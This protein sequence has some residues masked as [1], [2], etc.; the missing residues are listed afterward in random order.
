MEH[1]A[2]LDGGQSR[3][4]SP[5]NVDGVKGGGGRASEG[6][7]AA[8]AA[9]LGVGW[10]ISPSVDIAAGSTFELAAIDGPA[11]IRARCSMPPRLTPPLR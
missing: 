8:C 5:E 1:L 3:S 11:V 10:K 9:E 4:I 7:G 6:T 2:R